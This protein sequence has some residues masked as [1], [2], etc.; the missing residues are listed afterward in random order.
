MAPAWR[1][2]A[3]LAAVAATLA[4][5]GNNNA[6]SRIDREWRKKRASC[7]QE[8]CRHLKLPDEGENC[9]NA[10]TSQRCF[11]E[12]YAANPLEDGEFDNARGRA[13]TAC[14][15]RETKEAQAAAA[16]AKRAANSPGA[17]G[18]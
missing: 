3:V 1:L 9:V 4:T 10:C 6:L 12:V 17:A 13:F 7:E 2:L 15:R 14:L 11:D 18:L 16:A 5:A 8:Q